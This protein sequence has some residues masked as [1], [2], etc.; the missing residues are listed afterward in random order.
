MVALDRSVRMI[1]LQFSFGNPKLVPDS[2]MHLPHETPEERQERK[3]EIPGQLVI[4]PTMGC[5]LARI[6]D[7]IEASGYEMCDAAYK[8]RI[9]QSR[10]NRGRK[11]Y[12]MVRFLFVHHEYAEV[13]DF[14]RGERDKIRQD[15]DHICQE[16]MWRVRVFRNPFFHNGEMI[17]G[18][19]FLS[20]NFEVRQPFLE[21]NGQPIRMWQKDEQ[22]RKIG[23]A[24]LP[25]KPAY[26]L[27]GDSEIH[28][29]TA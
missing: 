8:P 28:L 29:E 23:N 6:V 25:I 2:V 19:C 26:I 9:S 16:A 10:Q 15:L 20:I 22:G 17:E 14:F 18:Q 12:H 13:S 3:S 21:P 7:E 4:E 11:T 1:S 24:P 27:R 5:S